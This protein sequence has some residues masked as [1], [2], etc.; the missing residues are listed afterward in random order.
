MI[1]HTQILLHLLINKMLCIPKTIISV[2]LYFP[3]FAY[4]F[5]ITC[6]LNEG[7]LDDNK[8][9]NGCQHM[10]MTNPPNKILLLF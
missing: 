7:S 2:G 4:R 10:F 9:T 1:V 6:D 8:N 3:M 5:M